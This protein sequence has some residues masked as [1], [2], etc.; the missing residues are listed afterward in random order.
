LAFRGIDLPFPDQAGEFM[1][2]DRRGSRLFPGAKSPSR[3]TSRRR[4]RR[5][6]SSANDRAPGFRAGGCAHAAWPSQKLG[7]S[8]VM[9]QMRVDRED[10]RNKALLK[11]LHSAIGA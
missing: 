7:F 8:F 9:K 5:A 3:A 2:R 1:R 6:S 4:R 10:H 11:A